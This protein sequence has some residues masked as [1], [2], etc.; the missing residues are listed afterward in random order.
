MENAKKT[1]KIP[2]MAQ[3]STDPTPL[4][5]PAGSPEKWDFE[6]IQRLL[7]AFLNRCLGRP[8]SLGQ[9]SALLDD[10]EDIPK[11]KSDQIQGILLDLSSQLS[12]LGFI[13]YRLREDVAG[14][15]LVYTGQG[16]QQAVDTL[17]KRS[18]EWAPTPRDYEVLAAIVFRQPIH[19]AD[20]ERVYTYDPYPHLQKWVKRGVIEV[21]RTEGPRKYYRTTREFLRVFD[22]KSLESM[23]DYVEFRGQASRKF[24]WKIN[25]SASPAAAAGVGA[26]V[27][28]RDI[29]V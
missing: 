13:P 21:E 14:W 25:S 17:Q 28:S 18:L 5:E 22:L 19:A 15:S 11:L 7:F 6:A 4:P 16:L 10:V 23:P 29:H 9:L 27:E 24:N 1:D 20:I 3:A 26:T 12:D 2:L 8:V